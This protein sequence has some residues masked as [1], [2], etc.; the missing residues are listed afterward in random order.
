MAIAGLQN[1]PVLDSS[2]N[3]ESRSPL[4]RRWGN[5]DRLSTR[6]SSLLQMWRTLEGEHVMSHSQLRVGDR[7][8]QQRIHVSSADLENAHLSERQDGDDEDSL[9]DGNEI[10]NECQTWSQGQIRLQNEQENGNS[11]SSEQSTD[12]GEVERE[13]VRQ[14]FQEWMNSGVRGQVSDVSHVN[15]YSRAQCLGEN[16]CERVRVIRE[17]TQMTSQQRDTCG[18]SREEQAAHI[19]AQIERVRD[20][21]VVNHSEIGARRNIR[22]LCGRQALLDLLARA[23]RER[24][25]ELQGL[26]EHRPVSDFAHR[27]RI[28]S[29]LRGRFLQSG[30]L[31]QDERP[32]SVAASELGLLRQ[33][34]SVS[35]LREGFL[36]RLDNFI[37]GPAI[38]AQSDT[39]SYNDI[40]DYRNEQ[41]QTNSSFEDLDAIQEQSE[42]CNGERDIDELCTVPLNSDASEDINW[43]EPNAQEEQQVHDFE[44]EER[45]GQPSFNP[46]SIGRRDSVMENAGRKWEGNSTNEQLQGTSGNESEEQGCQQE[47]HEVFHERYEPSGEECDVHGS[48][49]YADGYENNTTEGIQRSHTFPGQ[50]E[51]QES[52]T[53]TE[54]SDWQQLDNAEFSGWRDGTAEGTDGNWRESDVNHWYQETSGSEGDEHQRLQQLHEEWHDN[55]QQDDAMDNLLEGSSAREADPVRRFDTFSFRDDDNVYS[56]EIRELLSRRSVSN[57]LQSDFRE[58]LNQLIQSYAERQAHASVDWELD[59]MLPSPLSPALVEQDVPQS[60]NQNQDWPDALERTPFVLPPPPVIPSHPF[61]GPELHGDNWPQ[62]N[63]HQHLGI[64]RCSSHIKYYYL[65]SQFELNIV[66]DWEQEWEIINDLRIDMAR[67]QQR[68]NNMQRMLEACMDMQLELQRAVRQ[69]VSAALNRS[70][71]STEE[72]DDRCLPK[73]ES[74]WDHVRKGICCICCDRNIDSLLYRCGHMCA[75]SKCADKLV[76]GRGNCPMCRAP[77]VEMIRAYSVQ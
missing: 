39:T 16:E 61:W 47:A 54:D 69:E 41:T 2:F 32:S 52:I 56:T 5:H 71:C 21:L 34:Q 63:L 17:W 76:Q 72:G 55:G 59:G 70:A 18:S 15:N 24:Q 46:E 11:S 20:G 42:P 9:G 74:K 44:N 6:T 64:V 30:R 37:P 50:G 66:V 1:V 4:S 28:Q 7:L 77:V 57:L 31:V 73:D 8:L 43:Q 22:Q 33:R 13:R 65:G 29:L 14:I 58:S 27:N 12:F 62:N 49:I 35:G 51:W 75:C 67:L 53:D 26:L 19:G 25:R 60:G 45:E 10:A 36:S 38:T 40:N 3:R 68:M 48:S 23:E